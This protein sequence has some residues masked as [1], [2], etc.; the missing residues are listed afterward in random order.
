MQNYLIIGAEG[1]LGRA[2]LN[3][4]RPTLGKI[5]F[6][7]SKDELDST[8]L[9]KLQFFCDN[10]NINVLVNFAFKVGSSLNPIDSSTSND[11]ICKNVFTL[12]QSGTI[13]T[14]VNFGTALYYENNSFENEDDLTN[15]SFNNIN[16]KYL[17]DKIFLLKHHLQ[18]KNQLDSRLIVV[19]N[20]INANV[21]S[22]YLFS[23]LLDLKDLEHGTFGGRGDDIRSF[24]GMKDF[25]L[26]LLTVLRLKKYTFSNITNNNNILNIGNQEFFTIE[27]FVR[28]YISVNNIKIKSLSFNNINLNQRSIVNFSCNLLSN[29]IHDQSL[30][31]QSTKECLQYIKLQQY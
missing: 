3:Y 25:C 15:P 28:L 14:L 23:K 31:I 19:P 17:R 5:I 9:E 10:N 2:F 11:L 30:S 21:P 13:E 22:K 4:I 20:I 7:P 1:Y 27:D 8:N 26:I 6:A 16:N 24:L 18:N 29:I 12:L